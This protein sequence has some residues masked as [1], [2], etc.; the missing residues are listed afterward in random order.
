MTTTGAQDIATGLLSILN[1]YKT[2]NPTLLR[3]TWP[4]RPSAFSEN[5]LAYVD[6]GPERVLHTSGTR[7]RTFTPTVTYVSSFGE[8][9]I[10]NRNLVRDGLLDAFTAGVS[11]ISG[12]KIIVTDVTPSEETVVNP[13]TGTASTY[14]TLIF[15]FAEAILLEGRSL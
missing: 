2:A 12:M 1:T 9:D 15:T 11:V 3:K 6:L 7:Q 13:S 10:G 4:E 14:P 5:P 8:K